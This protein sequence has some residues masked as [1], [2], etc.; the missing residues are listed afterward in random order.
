MGVSAVLNDDLFVVDG[1][2]KR[3]EIGVVNSDGGTR[4]LLPLPKHDSP[5]LNITYVRGDA[6]GDRFAFVVDTLRG[7]NAALDI[8]GHLAARRIVVYRSDSGAQVASLDIYPP[9]PHYGVKLGIVPG[10]AFDLSP[11]GHVL[12]VLSEGILRITKI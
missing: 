1:R 12:A 8:G 11:D 9:V 7:G 4:F 6:T 10:F 5:A 3:W 2:K